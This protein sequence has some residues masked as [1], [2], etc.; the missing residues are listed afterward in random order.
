M[1][2]KILEFVVALHE[3]KKVTKDDINLPYLSYYG[4]SKYLRDNGII[5]VESHNERNQKVYAFTEKGSKFA[6]LVVQMREVLNG[7]VEKEKDSNI[8]KALRKNN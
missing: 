5:F 2:K 8:Q 1:S 6:A 7:S 4:I 3:N